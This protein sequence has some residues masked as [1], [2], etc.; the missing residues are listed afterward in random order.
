MV[1]RIA[2]RESELS[3]ALEQKEIALRELYHRTRN[4]MQ[5]ISSL[6]FLKTKNHEDA[7][8]GK[9]INDINLKI[10]AISLVHQRIYESDNLSNINMN[11]YLN[12]IIEHIDYFN[13][14]KQ[15]NE[16]QFEL[17]VDSIS[18]SIDLAI[19]LGL[20]ITELVLNSLTHAF[21]DEDNPETPKIGIKIKAEGKN[22]LSLLYSD[23]GT[24]FNRKEN[25]SGKT[26]ATGLM[27][28]TSLVESQLRGRIDFN[29][30]NGFRCSV[31]FSRNIDILRF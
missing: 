23:N 28:I 11:R 6:L 10:N 25:L 31:N 26:E 1:H 9:I 13:S 19:P 27:L 2:R 21:N 20:I 8:L 17:D 5:T 4:N 24:G 16:I 12:D 30:D 14:N 22:D 7:L 29:D 15:K 3:E 18:I